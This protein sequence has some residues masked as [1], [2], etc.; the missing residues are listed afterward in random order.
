MEQDPSSD[1]AKKGFVWVLE[2][3]AIAEG[4]KST[5]RYRKTGPN[6]KVV[7]SDSRA[8]QRQASGRKG[9]QA[10]RRA[11]GGKSKRVEAVTA[12]V[13]ALAEEADDP[14]SQY[15]GHEA[16][17]ESDDLASEF[18]AR[19]ARPPMTPAHLSEDGSC[20]P[21]YL[22]LTASLSEPSELVQSPYTINDIVG[23][24]DS[25]PGESL[26][27]DSPGTAVDPIMAALSLQ[28]ASP[29]F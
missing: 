22:P 21:Y 8:L 10:A 14:S 3:S 2:P 5:T 13:A 1:N 25:F 28:D 15:Y 19:Q 27:C 29:G 23:V 4:V 7:K 12:A 11:K 18:S 9:G 20:Y 26:F 24:A 16:I 17:P 6:K